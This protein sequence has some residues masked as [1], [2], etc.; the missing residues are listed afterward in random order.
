[1]PHDAVLSP[2]RT[3]EQLVGA[4]SDFVPLTVPVQLGRAPGLAT[5]AS[6]TAC[7][8]RRAA[9]RDSV[10]QARTARVRSPTRERRREVV[11]R[12]YQLEEWGWR[13]LQCSSRGPRSRQG[14]RSD[15]AATPIVLRT[16]ACRSSSP[17]SSAMVEMP[18]ARVA[19]ASRPSSAIMWKRA[20]LASA[21]GLLARR[22]TD[23]PGARRPPRRVF[24]CLPALGLDK[25]HEV[26][27]GRSAAAAALALAQVEERVGGFA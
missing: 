10:A 5:H 22:R 19:M 20:R 13:D 12:P 18:R 1:M 21:D 15:V 3:C 11:K 7:P 23:R 17:S 16:L 24:R 6:A 8:R 9:S 27:D 14:R 26:G 2:A 25:V 4:R